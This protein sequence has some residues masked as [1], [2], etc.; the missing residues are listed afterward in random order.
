MLSFFATLFLVARVENVKQIL[1][2]LFF[3]GNLFN[4]WFVFYPSW[5]FIA[6]FT[7]KLFRFYYR[8]QVYPS[9]WKDDFFLK[10][11]AS[12]FLHNMDLNL[13]VNEIPTAIAPINCTHNDYGCFRIQIKIFFMNRLALEA[14]FT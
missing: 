10:A 1:N 2:N 14:A 11:K 3:V 4:H 5:I 9:V 6:T 7:E 8:N 13:R 12:I